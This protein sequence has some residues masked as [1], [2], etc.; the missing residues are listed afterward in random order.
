MGAHVRF[1]IDSRDCDC[2]IF[3]LAHAGDLRVKPDPPKQGPTIGEGAE[4]AV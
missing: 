3:Q 1:Y 4:S 2:E